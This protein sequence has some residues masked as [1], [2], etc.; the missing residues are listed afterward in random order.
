MC[1]ITRISAFIHIFYICRSGI[2]AVCT[3]TRAGK[4]R[5]ASAASACCLMHVGLNASLHAIA[6]ACACV[7]AHMS[8][9]PP[10]L[11]QPYHYEGFCVVA[12]RAR[13][14][15]MNKSVNMLHGLSPTRRTHCYNCIVEEINSSRRMR[16]PLVYQS[17]GLRGVYHHHCLQCVTKWYTKMLAY[18]WI[19][20][21]EQNKVN[22]RLAKLITV[23]QLRLTFVTTPSCSNNNKNSTHT[24]LTLL[25]GNTPVAHSHKL[26]Q[27]DCICTIFAGSI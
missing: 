14:A 18:S 12:H 13:S 16:I 19:N 20:S 4:R 27:P 22:H 2:N 6:C 7:C 26:R 21:F 8:D 23:P 10:T 25:D 17:P 15:H 5:R 11:E 3:P 1:T 9:P 24:K